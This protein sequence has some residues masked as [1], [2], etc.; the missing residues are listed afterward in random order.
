MFASEENKGVVEAHVKR[1]KGMRSQRQNPHLAQPNRKDGEPAEET[2]GKTNACPTRPC[3]DD[4]PD[5]VLIV[6]GWRRVA[7]K[8]Q[9]RK[10]KPEAGPAIKLA[11]M[12]VA[13]PARDYVCG[14]R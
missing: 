7:G 9:T 8:S 12:A 14:L 1:P 5:W 10:L 4:F 2:R 6:S 13:H 3:R 11:Y